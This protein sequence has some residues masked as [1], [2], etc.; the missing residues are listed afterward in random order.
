LTHFT[1]Q[2]FTISFLDFIFRISNVRGM[3][4][5]TIIILAVTGLGLL[6]GNVLLVLEAI[7]GYEEEL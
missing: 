2:Y 5:I 6:V 4:I 3:E 1:F 7:N